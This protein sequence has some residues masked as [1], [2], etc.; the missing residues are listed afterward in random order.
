MKKKW[1]KCSDSRLE[2]REKNSTKVGREKILLISQLKKRWWKNLELIARFLTCWIRTMMMSFHYTWVN[3]NNS[4]FRR[5]CGSFWEIC[6]AHICV[7]FGME[8]SSKQLKIWVWSLL[9]KWTKDGPCVLTPILLLPFRGLIERLSTLLL[10][11]TYTHKHSLQFPYLLGV[12]LSSS[13][14]RWWLDSFLPGG[15]FPL[16]QP[17]PSTAQ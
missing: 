13:L 9:Y 1:P 10:H 6:V 11:I 12:P 5:L 15:S 7:I 17:C 3:N 8:R 2:R 16:M 14:L 4:F